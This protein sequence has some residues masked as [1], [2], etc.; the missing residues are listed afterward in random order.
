MPSEKAADDFIPVVCPTCHTRLSP[1]WDQAGKKIVCPDCG[2]KLRIP[3]PKSL[4]PK[5]SPEAKPVDAYA[6]KESAKP[7]EAERFAEDHILVVCSTCHTRLHPRWDQAGKKVICPDCGT[8]LRIPW[9]KAPT[10]K[11]GPTP[12][13]IGEYGVGEAIKPV[14]APTQ[15]LSAQALVYARPVPPPPRWTFFSGVFPFPWYRDNVSKWVYLSIGLLITG[16]VV[17]AALALSGVG[18]GVGS[19]GAFAVVGVGFFV[20]PIAWL[21]IWTFSY[22]AACCLAVLEETAAG[23]DEINWPE[24]GWREWLWKF[25]Y[26]G[27]LLSLVGLAATGIGLLVRYQTGLFWPPFFATIFVLYPFALLSSLEAN[28]IWVVISPVILKSL[29]KLIWAW[30]MFYLEV[31]V[32]A[33]PVAGLFFFLYLRHPFWTVLIAAPLVSALLL[34]YARLLGRLAWK[35][36]EQEDPVAET[37]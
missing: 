26:T 34:L 25:L 24:G 5:R 23:N 17:A 22:A 11:Q 27:Y 3:W 28:S 20:L 8:K 37:E 35:I 10:P 12:E 32:L 7:K 1:R 2:T 21:T 15:F 13:Q 9:P 19:V 30:F 6:V 18:G 36:T 33:A 16:E 14:Y 29:F 31:A 4:P